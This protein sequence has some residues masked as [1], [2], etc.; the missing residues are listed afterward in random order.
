[1]SLCPPVRIFFSVRM[2][3]CLPGPSPPGSSGAAPALLPS[4]WL[5]L[6]GVK[7]QL[8]CLLL[9]VRTLKWKGME[10]G[11]EV[12]APGPGHPDVSWLYSQ[13]SGQLVLFLN[14]SDIIHEV[15]IIIFSSFI[16]LSIYFILIRTLKMKSTIIILSV[17]YSIKCAIQY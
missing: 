5:C 13:N 16:F 10:G 7:L 14:F 3:T 1:M 17:Q 6:V 4:A 2:Q 8:E 9:P 11:V 12:E 15:D